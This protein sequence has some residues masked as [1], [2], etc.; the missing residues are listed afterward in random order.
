MSDNENGKARNVVDLVTPK[1]VAK[2]EYKI[3]SLMVK[4]D[5]ISEGVRVLSHKVD[6]IQT[7]V[8]QMNTV[9]GDTQA[10]ALMARKSTKETHDLLVRFDKAADS[11]LDKIENK[12]AWIIGVGTGLAAMAGALKLFL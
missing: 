11:R 8:N 7:S 10:A 9:L 1:R 2:N 5:A 12:L 6:L 3:D 4:T